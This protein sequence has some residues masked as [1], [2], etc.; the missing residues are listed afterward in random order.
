MMTSA[1]SS[2]SR[3]SRC[4]SLRDP[5]HVSAAAKAGNYSDRRQGA[6]PD[7]VKAFEVGGD[8]VAVGGSVQVEDGRSASGETVS[9][10]DH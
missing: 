4:G 8:H 7:V 3:P 1:E 10:L 5:G 2:E 6:R 9:V